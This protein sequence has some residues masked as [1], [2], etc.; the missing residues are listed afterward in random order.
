M[1]NR[2]MGKIVKSCLTLFVTVMFSVSIVDIPAQAA[3]QKPVTLN[4]ATNGTTGDK[5]IFS[6]LTKFAETVSKRTEGTLTIKIFPAG[7]LVKGMEELDALKT[8]SIDL[9]L[10]TDPWH[11]GSIP[12]LGIETLPFLYK[13]ER[14]VQR[15]LKAGVGN[16]LRKEFLKHNIVALDWLSWGFLELYGKSDFTDPKN[17]KGMKIRTPSDIVAQTIKQF[18]ASPAF[19]ATAEVFQ[20]VQRGTI[21]G[22]VTSMTAFYARK[23]YEIAK[24]GSLVY[25]WGNP[26][27]LVV[28]KVSWDKL[29][30]EW[31]KILQE[32]ATHIASGFPDLMMKDDLET[33]TLSGQNGTK[34]IKELTKERRAEWVSASKPIWADFVKRV[35]PVGQELIDIAMQAQQ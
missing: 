21:D 27:T 2:P 28:S 13:D 30:P 5:A 33:A 17:L 6:Q 23:F 12:L 7:S 26:A 34:I 3:T 9:S 14:G 1:E 22:M 32:E 19:I 18:G 15:A 20:A 31:Q 35:G 8:G 25:M 16:A 11:Q 4:L 10:F 29:P 24:F